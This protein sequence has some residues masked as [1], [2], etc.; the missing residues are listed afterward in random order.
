MRLKKKKKNKSKNLKTFFKKKDEH[1][2]LYL[3]KNI[4]IKI[5]TDIDKTPTNFSHS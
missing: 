5:K 4:S 1:L 3:T 2:K